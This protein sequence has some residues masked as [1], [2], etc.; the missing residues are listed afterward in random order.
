MSVGLNVQEIYWGKHLWNIKRKREEVDSNSLTLMKGESK[1]E[2]WVTVSDHRRGLRTFLMESSWAKIAH[3]IILILNGDGSWSSQLTL[4]STVGQGKYLWMVSERCI[5]ISKMRNI[6]ITPVT[7]STIV[8]HRPNV[9]H[10][11]ITFLVL[12]FHINGIIE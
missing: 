11:R 1:K 6:Y 12:E 7:Q 8:N 3:W 9:H 4:L 5:S 10:Y 2:F